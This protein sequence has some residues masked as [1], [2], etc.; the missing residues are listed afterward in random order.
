MVV[1]SKSYDVISFLT[2]LTLSEFE[3][4]Q[5]LVLDPLTGDQSLL[6]AVHNLILEASI[7]ICFVRWKM[8]SFFNSTEVTSFY[9]DFFFLGVFFS[10][11]F[12][13]KVNYGKFTI[14]FSSPVRSSSVLLCLSFLN[15]N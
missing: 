11:Y 8:P 10:M 5:D 7:E 15:F 12:Q 3:E 9:L 2:L 6:H 13:V 4:L 1:F 14:S